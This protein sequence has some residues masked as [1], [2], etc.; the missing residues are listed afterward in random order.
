LK[1]G[2]LQSAWYNYF[3]VSMALEN[4]ER[5]PLSVGSDGV[6]R[7]AGT[8]VT[9]DTVAEA[10]REGSTPEEII[11]Q[12]PGLELADVYSVLGYMLRH[13]DE[14]AAYLGEG[15]ES[16]STICA[17]NER[18]FNPEGIRARLLARKA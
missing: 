8:R 14:V 4:P 3:I 9:L 18:K 5:V 6:I 15:A 16:R 1:F 2:I 11:Q 12:Y 17:E 13:R 7:V 10:F